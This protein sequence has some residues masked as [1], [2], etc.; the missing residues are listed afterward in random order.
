MPWRVVMHDDRE[1]HVSL[2]AERRANSPN[3]TLVLGFRPAGDCSH[4]LWANFPLEAASRAMLFA[5]AERIPPD[6]LA[7]VLAERLS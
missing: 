6:R 4:P 3:W 1:W 5:H 7:A 2:A